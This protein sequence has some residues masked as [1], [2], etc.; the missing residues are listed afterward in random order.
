MICPITKQCVKFVMPR[1]LTTLN[2][3]PIDSIAMNTSPVTAKSNMNTVYVDLLKTI[4]PTTLNAFLNQAIHESIQS[5]QLNLSK[6][7]IEIRRRS[8]RAEIYLPGLEALEHKRGMFVNSLRRHLLP[9]RSK[10][11]NCPDAHRFF[12]KL[13]RPGNWKELGV[14]E[15]RFAT[16]EINIRL[17]PY[18]DENWIMS[19]QL[20]ADMCNGTWKPKETIPMQDDVYNLEQEIQDD[21]SKLERINQQVAEN[22]KSFPNQIDSIIKVGEMATKTQEEIYT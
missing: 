18:S 8:K 17:Q 19:H 5:T 11:S 20:V 10:L 9:L 6:Q 16:F 3:C 7:A 22:L 2:C 21:L 13:L 4:S 12:D 15:S 14:P 1:K